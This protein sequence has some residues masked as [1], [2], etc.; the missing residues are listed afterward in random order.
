MLAIIVWL[1]VVLNGGWSVHV[2]ET[3]AQPSFVPGTLRQV[4]STCM[5]CMLVWG[6]KCAHR[7]SLALF[8]GLQKLG[9]VGDE[10][11]R[12]EYRGSELERLR[13]GAVDTQKDGLSPEAN[14]SDNR[15]QT[16]RTEGTIEVAR[17]RDDKAKVADGH[18]EKRTNRRWV[19]EMC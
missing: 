12:Q 6:V 10:L 17:R 14:L 15:I 7:C 5:G 8:R 1:I 19:A 3:F 9:L 11:R 2:V 16:L 13:Q 4:V 18:R